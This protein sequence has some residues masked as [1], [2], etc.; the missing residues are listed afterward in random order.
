MKIEVGNE[1]CDECGSRFNVCILR[2]GT[3][4]VSLCELCRNA[5]E[6]KLLDIHSWKSQD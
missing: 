3:V 1:G 6:D 2:F 5:L 4:R